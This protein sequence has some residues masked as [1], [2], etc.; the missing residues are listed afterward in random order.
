MAA[1]TTCVNLVLLD[2]CRNNPLLDRISKAKGKGNPVDAAGGFAFDSR[3]GKPRE[4]YIVYSTAADDVAEDGSGKNS[5]FT[6]ALL[7]NLYSPGL[8]F[9][10]M[11]RKVRH[12]VVNATNERQRPEEYGDITKSIVMLPRPVASAPPA[13]GGPIMRSFEP[14]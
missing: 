1:A 5:P 11:I 10:L 13:I 3:T 8:D 9:Q 12:A 4:T 6:D 2:A 7:K 14:K